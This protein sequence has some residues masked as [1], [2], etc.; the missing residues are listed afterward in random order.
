M[1]VEA[2]TGV[3][4]RIK[5]E[6]LDSRTGVADLMLT[7]LDASGAVVHGPSLTTEL[8]GGVYADDW[9]PPSG[10]LFS[11]SFTS[12]TDPVTLVSFG[13][14]VFSESQTAAN[15]NATTAYVGRYKRLKWQYFD[16]R[17]GVTDLMVTVRNDAD[18]I[19]HGPVLTYELT[20]GVYFSDWVPPA[21]GNYT[22]YFDSAS[23]PTTLSAFDIEVFPMVPLPIGAAVVAAGGA[24]VA[25]SAQINGTRTSV[26]SAIDTPWEAL[27]QTVDDHVDAYNGDD[28]VTLHFNDTCIPLDGAVYSVRES[29]REENGHELVTI[30]RTLSVQ[31]KFLPP[32]VKD[33]GIIARMERDTPSPYIQYNKIIGLDRTHQGRTMLIIQELKGYK[34]STT[35]RPRYTAVTETTAYTRYT[36][37][38]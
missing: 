16:F 32:R 29:T 6:Y 14:M 36:P 27:R 30:E 11:G 26:S 17:T 1:I 33:K 10:G 25:G 22:G 18:V 19:V 15:A 3:S 23:D 9:T 31:S 4:K 8:A 21:E 5:W 37:P 2:Y 24:G 38:A 28:E 7:V 13:I 12:V 34:L 35:V 20:N